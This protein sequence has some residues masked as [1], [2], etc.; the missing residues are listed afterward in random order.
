MPR[1]TVAKRD[2]MVFLAGRR[3]M[4]HHLYPA[5]SL[6][7]KTTLSF[8]PRPLTPY[9]LRFWHY[10]PLISDLCWEAWKLG[11]WEAK[12]QRSD[13]RSQTSVQIRNPKS[14]IRI[15]QSEIP[16]APY[17]LRLTPDASRGLL[18]PFYFYPFAPHALRFT[19]YAA[20][21]L[22]FVVASRFVVLSSERGQGN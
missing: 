11:G 7:V 20:C 12:S 9:D 14:A 6:Y 16:P 5:R 1:S 19:T 13:V 17:P 10:Y 15:P 18:L 21:P 8:V 4:D 22:P 2:S 3:A